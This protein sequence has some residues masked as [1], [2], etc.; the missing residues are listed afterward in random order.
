MSPNSPP[1]GLSI[2]PYAMLLS[3]PVSLAPSSPAGLTHSWGFTNLPSIPIPTRIL[4]KASQH[5]TT[6]LQQ[7][8]SDDN[9]EEALESSP[10][11]FYNTV[12]ETVQINFTGEGWDAD[13]R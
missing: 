4:H 2:S 1:Q 7:R 3:T 13:A 12:V 10:A 9:F 8:M 5:S 11:L 6:R